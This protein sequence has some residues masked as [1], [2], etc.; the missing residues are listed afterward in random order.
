MTITRRA[1][2]AGLLLFQLIIVPSGASCDANGMMPSVPPELPDLASPPD[3][4]AEDPA[5]LRLGKVTPSIGPTSGE[6]PIELEGSG[7]VGGSIVR[8][9]GRDAAAVQVVSSTRIVA[10]LPP[11]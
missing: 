4:A 3:G 6:L 9:A 5:L 7:F 10:L 11:A 2:A 1:I 8:V